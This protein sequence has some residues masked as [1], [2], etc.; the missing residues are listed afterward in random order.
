MRGFKIPVGVIICVVLWALALCVPTVRELPQSFVFYELQKIGGPEDYVKTFDFRR[1]PDDVVGAAWRAEIEFREG[2][3]DA[4][5]A[6]AARYPADLR[7]KSLQLF[8]AAEAWG[9]LNKA[10]QQQQ[11]KLDAKQESQWPKSAQIAREGARI[12]PDNVFWPWMEAAFEFAAH[13]DDLALRVFERAARC[14]RYEDY[15][16]VINRERIAWLERQRRLSWEQKTMLSFSASFSQ[17]GPMRRSSFLASQRARALRQKGQTG[18]SLSVEAGV[19][20]ANRLARRDGRYSNTAINSENMARAGLEQF[21]G[22]ARPRQMDAII[23][24]G[25][26]THTT[27]LARTWARLTRQS[28][29]PELASAADFVAEPSI[30]ST[31][32]Q[33]DVWIEIYG[34][35]S[36]WGN[37]AVS[38]PFVMS[39]LAI[40]VVLGA[41]LWRA[42]VPLRF[43]RATPTRGQVVACANFSFWLLALSAIVL[44]LFYGYYLNPFW[45]QAW[46]V[47]AVTPIFIALTILCWLL[48][49]WF[50]SWR[51]REQ[52]ESATAKEGLLA[53]NSARVWFTR[54]LWV[55]AL[56]CLLLLSYTIKWSGT[57]F[58]IATFAIITS[59]AALGALTLSWRTA[60][61]QYR[62]G[63]Q[64][65]HRS[66]GVLVVMWS[67]AFLIIALA[68]WPLRAQL[69]R[70]LERKLEIGEVAWMREQVARAK[71]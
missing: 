2:N 32:Q 7:I 5:Q 1:L 56:S 57:S 48:P 20:N 30:Y 43:G 71:Q 50:V 12:E 64:L 44:C 45:S 4:L 37:I 22:I 11:T 66:L 68:V 8:L 55:T 9:G 13:R 17:L 53:T 62:F 59:V 52:A 49:V 58:D 65:A 63:W 25:P 6:V 40:T 39:V 70:S 23:Y 29:R 38:A 27:N 3:R 35:R 33:N 26:T 42:G 61:H 34:M 41:L 24:A 18:R 54:V 16:S 51:T 67:A 10:R 28:G 46:S 36:L 15:S 31:F 60:H 14:T 21:L 47:F 19:L 69:N